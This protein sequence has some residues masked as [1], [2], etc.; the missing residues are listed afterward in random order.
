MHERSMKTRAS[1]FETAGRSRCSA[2]YALTVVCVVG[3][4]ACRRLRRQIR[5]IHELVIEILHQGRFDD[6]EIRRDVEIA[7]GVQRGMTNLQHLTPHHLA[8]KPHDL[9]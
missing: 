9:R 5:P 8:L 3:L 7:G 1:S 2:W 4:W 6:L